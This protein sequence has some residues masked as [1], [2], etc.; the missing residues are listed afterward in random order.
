MGWLLGTRGESFSRGHLQA[1]LHS[2]PL[3]TPPK[4]GLGRVPT[5]AF[6][7]TACSKQRHRVRA[8]ALPWDKEIGNNNWIIVATLF[9]TGIRK[10]KALRGR[11]TGVVSNNRI[12]SYM[13]GVRCHMRHGL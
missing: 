4:G 7:P 13:F 11:G 3:G 1:R 12:R 2:E 10:R 5:A 6:Q 9:W 8:L